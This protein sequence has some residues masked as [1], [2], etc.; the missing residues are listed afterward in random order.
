MAFEAGALFGADLAFLHDRNIGI[1]LDFVD[2]R[3]PLATV[4]AEGIEALRFDP[5]FVG[6]ARRDGRL[7]CILDAML[8]L[9][10][11]LGIATLASSGP[12]ALT[13]ERFKF[14]YVSTHAS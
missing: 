14:D 8:G 9:A 13:P 1:V 12:D 11:D 10:H 5:Q 3:T 6:R 2:E 7:A 4:G